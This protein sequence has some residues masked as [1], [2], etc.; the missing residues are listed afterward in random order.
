MER[1]QDL[2]VTAGDRLY[3]IGSQD[4]HFP[5]IGWHI[6][7]EMGGVWVH[8]QKVLDGFW[9]GLTWDGEESIIP[10]AKAFRVAPTHTEHR[11]EEADTWS[12]SRRQWV[13][14]GLPAM[15]V[16]LVMTNALPVER[17][18]LL[19]VWARSN[20]RPGWLAECARGRDHAVVATDPPGI[21]MTNDRHPDWQAWISG[22]MTDA[23]WFVTPADMGPTPRPDADAL[24]FG[25]FRMVRRLPPGGHTKIVFWIVAATADWRVDRVHALLVADRNERFDEKACRLQRLD[26]ASQLTVPDR[27]IE[28]AYA[29]AK[30]QTDW[31][32][33]EVPG[34]GRGLGAGVPEFPWWFACDSGY[35]LQGVL[36]TGGFELAKQTVELLAEASARHNENGRVI[37]ELSG[38][39]VVYNSGTTQESGQ[40]CQMVWDV[41][42]WTGDRD[43]LGRMLPYAERALAWLLAQAYDGDDL[44]YGYAMTEV[45][46]LNLKMIDTAVYTY[47]ALVAMANVAEVQGDLREGALRQ[48]AA[49]LKETI[50]TRFW[51]PEQGMFGDVIGSS[52]AMADRLRRWSD[53]AAQA[54]R[55]DVADAL[56][57]LVQ[58]RGEAAIYNLRNSVIN[59]PM[60][61]KI[62]SEVQAQSALHRMRESDFRSPY[63]L[64]LS[65]FWQTE[66]MTISTG[67]Q[68]VAE[69]QYAQ[70]DAALDWMHRLADTMDLRMPGSMSEI[71]PDSGCFV[72]AWSI[73]GLAVP[74]VEHFFGLDPHAGD[75]RVTIHC[76]MPHAWSWAELTNVRVADN[77]LDLRYR[78][79]GELQTL[80]VS[81]REAWRID[82]AD[83]WTVE[84]LSQGAR[85]NTRNAVE[86]PKDGYVKL[87]YP[88]S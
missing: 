84:T 11:Y 60:E 29:W 72:Q 53:A 69:A 76:Q 55:P 33:R 59:T 85:Q 67:R 46:L 40:F 4:G 31:L 35:A 79:E 42:R 19:T 16:E 58:S 17:E 78:R 43:F 32:V 66:V 49:R 50:R 23:E 51:I 7:G 24:S 2:Y 54:D 71:S 48:R 18:L 57:S 34:L 12:V 52:K 26:A 27:S 6:R 36:A 74:V 65:G 21:L 88:S 62:A 13:P 87:I 86:L 64:Y 28:H 63:G 30:F 68:A 5:T 37:H 22:T 41:F 80:S 44:A 61:L 83:G 73:Y 47:G 45:D 20:L 39:G 82:V 15:V 9:M 56:A 25:G 70:V 14:D 81:T 75:R 8:P 3:A 10:R 38:T 77:R 1:L